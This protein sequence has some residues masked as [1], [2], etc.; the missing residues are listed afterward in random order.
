MTRDEVSELLHMLLFNVGNATVQ[1]WFEAGRCD[2]DSEVSNFILRKGAEKRFSGHQCERAF[3]ES[4]VGAEGI[5]GR[6]STWEGFLS[7]IKKRTKTDRNTHLD[8]TMLPRG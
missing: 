2:S 7:C 6:A 5:G 1:T 8:D 4:G 3:S